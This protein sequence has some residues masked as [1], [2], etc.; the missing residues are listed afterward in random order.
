MSLQNRF[1]SSV[2]TPCDGNSSG[3][4]L[5][6]R[7]S[8]ALIGVPVTYVSVGAERDAYIKMYE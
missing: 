1:T 3:C 4:S 7:L 5:I 6:K 8:P 2:P